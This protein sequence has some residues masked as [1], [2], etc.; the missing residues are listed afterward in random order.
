MIKSSG[1]RIFASNCDEQHKQLER[2]IQDDSN[3]ITRR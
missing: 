1:F 2:I 3:N